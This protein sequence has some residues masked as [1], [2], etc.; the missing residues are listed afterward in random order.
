M[1]VNT[2][3]LAIE[4]TLI[5]KS[6]LGPIGFDRAGRFWLARSAATV[7]AWDS[8]LEKTLSRHKLKGGIYGHH[9]DSKGHMCIV[10]WSEK[11]YKLRVYRLEPK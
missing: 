11:E 9:L 7:E 5:D 4:N 1:V 10:T 3:T 6:C 2:N 8:R